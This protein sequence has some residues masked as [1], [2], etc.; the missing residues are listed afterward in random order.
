MGDKDIWL[1]AIAIACF[2]GGLAQILKPQA[3]VKKKNPSYWFSWFDLW[4]HMLRSSYA[5]DAVRANGV[6]LLF[7]AAILGGHVAFGWWSSAP[8]AK[9]PPLDMPQQPAQNRNAGK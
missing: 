4:G 7:V 6:I 9:S 3:F 2:V 5:K 8:T 1:G